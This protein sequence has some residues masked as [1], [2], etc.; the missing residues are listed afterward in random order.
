M[1]NKK[2][3]NK[4][5]KDMYK[6]TSHG[7][8]QYVVRFCSSKTSIVKA[9]QLARKDFNKS[10]RFSK[11]NIKPYLKKVNYEDFEVYGY[12]K[13]INQDFEECF[14]YKNRVFLV[15]EKHIVTTVMVSQFIKK[16]YLP[17]LNAQVAGFEIKAEVEMI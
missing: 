11:K 3:S 15:K 5:L 13:T 7:I 2:I 17:F 9:T 8:D 12:K 4:K 16:K 14:I 10:V 6:F 1:K